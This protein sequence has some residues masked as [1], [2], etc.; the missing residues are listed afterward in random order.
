MAAAATV[1][2]LALGVSG[3]ALGAKPSTKTS[4][5]IHLGDGWQPSFMTV[6][7]LQQARIAALEKAAGLASSRAD[8]PNVCLDQSG[9][10]LVHG[11][12][13]V[14]T[15]HDN[16]ITADPGDTGVDANTLAALRNYQM[17]YDKNVF[18]PT[19]QANITEYFQVAGV[20]KLSKLVN[21]Q[22][23]YADID[24]NTLD[25]TYHWLPL[26][27]SSKSIILP[28]RDPQQ[29][30]GTYGSIDAFRMTLR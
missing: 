6:I 20:K 3:S 29:P 1:G 7:K 11:Q 26:I 13:E 19:S 30:A 12:F 10:T 22:A 8:G 27:T 2:L 9:Y 24:L 25:T 18:R 5:R 16:S 14:F 17:F 23:C 4:I 15:N 28:Y 21:A